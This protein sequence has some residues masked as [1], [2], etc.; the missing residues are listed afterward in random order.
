VRYLRLAADLGE[1]SL[2]DPDGGV[3]LDALGLSPALVEELG[4]W[5]AVY[6]PVVPADAEE[7]MALRD[8][9]ASL[10]RRGRQIADK[11][12]AELAPAKVDYYSEGLLRLLPDVAPEA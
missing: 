12:G 5:N 7:R 8:L 10:D 6:Q 3:S 1:P 11:I 9:I 2:S 4:A